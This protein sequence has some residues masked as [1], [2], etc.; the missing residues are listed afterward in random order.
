MIHFDL[1]TTREILA[2]I[3]D[4]RYRA[5]AEAIEVGEIELRARIAEFR[6]RNPTD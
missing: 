1:R 5:D 6:E 4:G 3:A 2:G